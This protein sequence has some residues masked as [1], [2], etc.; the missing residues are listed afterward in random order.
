MTTAIYAI[1]RDKM[2]ILDDKLPFEENK[3][4]KVTIDIPVEEPKNSFSF[5]K[6]AMEANIEGPPDWSE[7][8]DEYLYGV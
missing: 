7:H 5:F 3:R 4:L 2:L 1:Y 6:T 8:V